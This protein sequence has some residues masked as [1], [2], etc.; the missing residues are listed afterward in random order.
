MKPRRLTSYQDRQMAR[1]TRDQQWAFMERV[2]RLGLIWFCV[3]NKNGHHKPPYPDDL[4]VCGLIDGMEL[5]EWMGSHKEWWKIGRWSDKHYARPV[6]LTDA[7]R[8]ALAH[9]ERYDMELVTGG[10]VEPGW[11]AMP[12]PRLARRCA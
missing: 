4:E 6:R 10:L 3:W 11:C 9:R 7:G 8:A 1:R 5:L 2:A 12:A